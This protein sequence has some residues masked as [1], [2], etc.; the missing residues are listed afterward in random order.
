MTLVERQ[1]MGGVGIVHHKSVLWTV[2]STAALSLLPAIAAPACAQQPTGQL[3][4]MALVRQLGAATFVERKQAARKLNEAGL[5]AK[6]ALMLGIKDEDLE[7]RLGAQRVL[8][9]VLQNDFDAQIDAFLNDTGADGTHDL[10]GWHLFRQQV[11]GDQHARQLYADMLRSEADLLDALDRSD[12]SV[13]LLCSNRIESLTSSAM[14]VNGYRAAIPEATLATMLFVGSQLQKSPRIASHEKAAYSP[15][16]SRIYSI[17]TFPATQQT[18]L[19]ESHAKLLQQLL[20]SWIEAISESPQQYGL[21]YAMQLVLKY[22]L[23]DQG[24]RLCRKCS[25]IPTLHPMG[26]RTPPS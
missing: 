16:T 26:S 12:Q 25:R 23:R 22:D 2:C 20:M 7:V 17:M 6:P 4:H 10:P 14:S 9:Q 3:P 18:V 21:A 19:Q 15:L 5:A 1:S 13:E 24:P 11:G 8:V